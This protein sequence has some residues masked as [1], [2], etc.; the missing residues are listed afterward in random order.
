M[1]VWVM[2]DLHLSFGTNKPMD[3]FFGWKDYVNKIE[4]SW[5]EQIKPED[6]NLHETYQNPVLLL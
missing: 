5:K 3:N 1:S 6:L 4:T 2:A